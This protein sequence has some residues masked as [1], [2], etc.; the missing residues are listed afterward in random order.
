[1]DAAE[2]ASLLLVDGE[3]L[4]QLSEDV[5]ELSGFDA[6]RC[7]AR[8]AMHW[9][10]LPHNAACV[11][12]PL[13]D[14]DMRGQKVAHFRGTVASYERDLTDLPRRI[15]RAQQGQDVRGG[16]CWADFHT[17]G[18]LDAP[19]VLNVRAVDLPCAI[20]NPEEVRRGV[21]VRLAIGCCRV[22]GRT[23]CDRRGPRGWLLQSP[24]EA[25]LV[26]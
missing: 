25:L 16:G 9:I 23:T 1:M 18:I 13:D 6:S 7:G 17:D 15:E 20:P 11:L 5:S 2:V 26:L 24:C 22:I 3:G 8:V 12:A 14:A 4:A 19:E 21:I 10:A